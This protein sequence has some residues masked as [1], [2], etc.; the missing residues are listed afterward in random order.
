MQVR[1]LYLVRAAVEIV[2]ELL[3]SILLSIQWG[4]LAGVA[5]HLLAIRGA[6]HPLSIRWGRP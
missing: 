4:I 2:A 3:L 5:V 1:A 6:V